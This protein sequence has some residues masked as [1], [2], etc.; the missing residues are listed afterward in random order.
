[1]AD[2]G[3]DAGYTVYQKDFPA[4]YTRDTQAEQEGADNPLEGFAGSEG[5][6]DH[7]GAHILPERGKEECWSAPKCIHVL[8]HYG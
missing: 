3:R 4:T 6:Q 2:K 5:D 7:A 8:W 1:V